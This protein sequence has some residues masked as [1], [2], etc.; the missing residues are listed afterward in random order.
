MTPRTPWSLVAAAALL[1]GCWQSL[2]PPGSETDRVVPELGTGT[3][4]DDVTAEDDDIPS[5]DDDD[6]TANDD[7][8]TPTDDDDTTAP[9]DDDDT[10]PDD[11]DDTAPDDD[12]DTAPG[13]DDDTAPDDDD[14]T[15]PDA[16]DATGD[17][18]PFVWVPTSHHTVHIDDVWAWD[19]IAALAANGYGPRITS[20]NKPPSIA[21][22]DWTRNYHYSWAADGVALADSI[23]AILSDPAGAPGKVLI[24]ELKADSLDMIREAAE[25][26]ATVYPQWAGRW[27]AY[28]VNGEAVAYPGLNPAIDALLDANA[29]LAVELY[30]HQSR[31][32]EEGA[33]AY[34]RDLWLADFFS[35]TATQGRFDWLVQRRTNRGSA[36]HISV[37]FGVTDSFLNGTA[38][39]VFLDRM[40][41]VWV[42]RS[43]YR[44]FLLDENGGP[45][46]WKWDQ[47]YMSN[48]SR[49]LAFSTSYLHY[50]VIGSTSSRLG[51]VSCP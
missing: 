21:W 45:G 35:G 10:A 11:D 2:A 23:N 31:Y 49:D 37:V 50:S 32:C 5:G 39:A 27:G 15:A 9:D 43:G 22:N 17:D 29:L 16:D 12:D 30:P 4:D 51:Q 18:A 13:D 7:D 6:N 47:P 25:R 38:P 34:E 19:A 41:Y 26:M 46:A 28:I 40:F 42:T 48:T 24:D 3:D 8:N 33:T 36:S 1:T 44:S 20:Q 14:D